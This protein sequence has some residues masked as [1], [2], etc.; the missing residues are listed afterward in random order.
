VN[1]KTGALPL[2]HLLV[3]KVPT[4]SKEDAAVF[5]DLFKLVLEKVLSRVKKFILFFHQILNFKRGEK[6]PFTK[7]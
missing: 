6:I 4:V 7:I 3:T 5:W 2:L 1:S